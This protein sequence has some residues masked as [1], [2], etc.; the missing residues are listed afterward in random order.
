MLK[1]K[2]KLLV[3]LLI[4]LL[5]GGCSDTKMIEKSTAQAIYWHE[6]DR[7]TAA[8]INNGVVEMRRIPTTGYNNITLYTDLKDGELPWY[9]C[10]WLNNAFTGNHSGK[11]EVHIK[12]IDSLM[13][14][15]WNHGKFGSG[16][17]TR[18]N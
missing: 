16:T 18:I 3:V 5:C 10:E 12:N 17:T 2:S 7:Y 6:S 15:D 13:T 9:K 11:C 4:A 14:A 1:Y 8:I